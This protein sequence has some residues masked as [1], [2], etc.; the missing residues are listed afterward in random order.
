MLASNTDVADGESPEPIG[1]PEWIFFWESPEPM[2]GYQKAGLNE[3]FRNGPKFH[4]WMK[5]S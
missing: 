1:Q 4:P 3:T 2:I 5:F